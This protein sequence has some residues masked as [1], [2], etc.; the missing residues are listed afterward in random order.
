M[1]MP[2]IFASPVRFGITFI[3]AA[4]IAALVWAVLAAQVQSA[5]AAGTSNVK[6][7]GMKLLRQ[8]A[9][10]PGPARSSSRQAT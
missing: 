2:G 6:T 1:A 8:T 4:V 3:A 9:H 7:L 10:Q 5:S